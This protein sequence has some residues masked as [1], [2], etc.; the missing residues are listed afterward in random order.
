MR[1]LE[2]VNNASLNKVSFKEVSGINKNFA[3]MMLTC[4]TLK[5]GFVKS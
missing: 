3:T 1:T 2:L 5:I 4:F